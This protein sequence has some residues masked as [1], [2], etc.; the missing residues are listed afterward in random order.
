MMSSEHERKRTVINA[1][2]SG[3][4]DVALEGWKL[5][6]DIYGREGRKFATSPAS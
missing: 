5:V 3:L 6:W 4:M 2:M 1:G